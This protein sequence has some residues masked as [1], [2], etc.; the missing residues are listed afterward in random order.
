MD[1]AMNL[2]IKVLYT[3]LNTL[4]SPHS[5]KTRQLV[6]WLSFVWTSGY[7]NNGYVVHDFLLHVAIIIYESRT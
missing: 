2:Q 4:D 5:L 6:C 1:L 3:C 7:L